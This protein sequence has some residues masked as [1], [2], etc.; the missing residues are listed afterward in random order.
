[1]KLLNLM[2]ISLVLFTKCSNA[3]FFSSIMDFF[4]RGQRHVSLE[5]IDESKGRQKTEFDFIIV[6]A[7]TAGCALANRLTENPNWN[8]LLL[9]AGPQENLLMDVPLLVNFLQL[10]REVNW[11]YRTQSSNSSCLAMK[12]NRCNWPRG[13]VMGGSSV[14]NYMI[15]T[16]G[17]SRDY[18]KWAAMGNTGWSFAE[19][20]PYFKK[21][22][23]SVVKNSVPG[24]RG[25]NGP[26]T[27]S[28][29]KW[30]SQSARHFVKAAQE[31][32]LPYVDYNGPSQIGVSYLQASIK[33]GTR[34]SSNVG[35]LYPIKNRRNLFIRKLSMVTKVLINPATKTAYGVQYDHNGRSYAVY[36]R[37]EV[38]LSAGSIN[39]PQLLML[40]GIGPADHLRKKK[41]EPLVNLPVG[42]NLMDHTAPGAITVK[43]NVSTLSPET[44]TTQDFIDL[45]N[46]RGP[47]TSAGGC[48]SIMFLDLEDQKNMNAWP[49]I[50]LLQIASSIHSFDVFRLN[51]GLREDLYQT[52]FGNMQAV[53]Q[54]AFMVFPMVLRPKSRGRILLKNN[55]PYTYPKI[56]ANYF[57]DPEGHD[58]KVSVKGIKKTIEMLNTDAMRRINARLHDVPIPACAYLGFGTD[59]YWECHTRHF[60]FTI[61]HYSGTCKMGPANDPTAV[62]DPRLRVYG[63]QNLRVVDASIIPEIM[64]GHPNGPVYMIA[65]KAADMIKQDWSNRV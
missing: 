57:T 31:M 63:I 9:E 3:Q 44:F 59:A 61:Y 21:L 2:I 4:M 14:L 51:F 36:A 17:S 34:A 28:E 5:Q 1:M 43:V 12:N 55:N 33:S 13:R 47:L 8:V 40:S 20:L 19:V 65:E 30:K 15:Y 45:Q 58:I 6:G 18:D 60:T 16:R 11:G 7:G 25:R 56:Y 48:E 50:E 49:D 42:Y 22:E 24:W 32:G 29:V 26:I 39:T 64:A 41:I 53:N 54:N 23:D 46:G 62:V 38:I 37:K 52:M 35:Y 27:V 10:N